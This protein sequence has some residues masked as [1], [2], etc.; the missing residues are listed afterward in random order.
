MYIETKSKVKDTS[1]RADRLTYE[2][3]CVCVCVCLG[4]PHMCCRWLRRKGSVCVCVHRDLG[5]VDIP[6]FK[7]S[8]EIKKSLKYKHACHYFVVENLGKQNTYMS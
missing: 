4:M 1:A 2:Y 6:S 7:P 3:V 5:E 8:L